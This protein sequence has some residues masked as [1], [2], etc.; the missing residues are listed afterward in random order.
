[1]FGKNI[2]Y[3]NYLNTIVNIKNMFGDGYD[4]ES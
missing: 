4:I 3:L 2:E 1:M